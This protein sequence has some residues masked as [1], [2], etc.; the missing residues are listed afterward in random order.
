MTLN[1]VYKLYCSFKLVN[2]LIEYNLVI[3]KKMLIASQGSKLLAF[4]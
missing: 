3:N 2:L 1:Y 4:E